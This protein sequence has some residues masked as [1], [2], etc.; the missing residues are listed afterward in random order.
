[1]TLEQLV[2]EG[3]VV[4]DYAGDERCVDCGGARFELEPGN[5][6]LGVGMNSLG[7]KCTTPKVCAFCLERRR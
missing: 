6:L 1:M 4:D 2:P 7:M 5:V 3:P